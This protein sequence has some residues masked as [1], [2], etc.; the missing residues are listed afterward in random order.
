MIGGRMA[1]AVLLLVCSAC[2]GGGTDSQV[3]PSAIGGGAVS[4]ASPPTPAVAP[5]PAPAPAPAADS[6]F[7][8]TSPAGTDGSTLPA[9]YT[10]DGGGSTIALAWSNPPAG[11][12]EFA[13]L[14]STLP[15]DGTTKWNWVLYGIPK[16]TT[17]LVRNTSGVGTLGVGS[18]GPSAAYQPPCSQGPG[19]KLYTFT[20][21]ALSAPPV[22]AATPVTGA[23]L[24][25]AISS[26]TLGSATLNLSYTRPR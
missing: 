17:G 3:S 20:L 8:L 23:L 6:H 24:R 21:Y 10:C 4:P 26:I 14:M 9:E 18:D 15:G 25:G 16:S 22:P 2:A 12:Q 19:A 11:T 13:L 7:T 1:V 5:A